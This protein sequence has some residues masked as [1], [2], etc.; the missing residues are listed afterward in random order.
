MDKTYKPPIIRDHEIF[1]YY[2]LPIYV[3]KVGGMIIEPMTEELNSAFDKVEWE[4]NP[5]NKVSKDRFTSL[6]LDE[7]EC[8]SFLKEIDYHISQY[9][10]SIGHQPVF[11]YFVNAS[12]FNKLEYKDS[13]PFIDYSTSDMVGIYVLQDSQDLTIEFSESHERAAATWWLAHVFGNKAGLVFPANQL[14][15]LPSWLKWQI[16]PNKT[17]GIGKVVTFTIKFVSN[18][19]NLKP[20][21]EKL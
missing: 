1:P 3:S 2:Q 14:I 5:H 13:I 11:E 12:W 16:L 4:E 19:E 21:K 17:E 15:L 20:K 8:K 7:F 9:M 10:V 18:K 6:K